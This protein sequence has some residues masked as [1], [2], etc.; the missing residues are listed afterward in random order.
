MHWMR[1]RRRWGKAA[2]LISRIE[3]KLVIGASVL[4]WLHVGIPVT[5][6]YRKTAVLAFGFDMWTLLSLC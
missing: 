3:E 2:R 1:G 4:V 6:S 5:G